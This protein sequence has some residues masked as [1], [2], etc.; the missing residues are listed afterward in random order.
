MQD[1]SETVTQDDR[2][3]RGRFL[4]GNG[5]NGGRKPGSRNKL[6][7][8]F[9]A[10]FAADVQEHGASVI[11]RVRNER[12][13]VYLKVWADLLPRKT[14]FAVNIDILADVSDALQAFRIAAD[15]LGA[16][17]KAGMR[18][19]RKIAPRL[20]YYDADGE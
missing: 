10:K 18:R 17:P 13:E 20:E 8:E 12:P 15:L 7:E 5:G 14:E 1:M 11:E 3:Q 2:D 4:A 9:L 19:L 6:G 16:D